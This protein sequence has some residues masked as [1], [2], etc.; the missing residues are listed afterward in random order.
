MDKAEVPP[1]EP[2]KTSKERYRKMK[3][4]FKLLVYVS[5]IGCIGYCRV[6]IS[7]LEGL[8]LGKRMLPRGVKK[9]STET[10]E[11]V[12]RQKVAELYFN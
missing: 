11:I 5:R 3:R 6:R 2:Q 9:S 7:T 1:V 4:K 8:C 12:P 10:A